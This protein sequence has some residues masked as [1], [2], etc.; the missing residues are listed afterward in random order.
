MSGE[1]K[2]PSQADPHNCT[3]G[4]PCVPKDLEFERRLSEFRKEKWSAAE[5]KLDIAWNDAI[6][7]AMVSVGRHRPYCFENHNL[8]TGPNKNCWLC[9]KHDE[10]R[11]LKRLDQAGFIP[12]KDRVYKKAEELLENGKSKSYRQGVNDILAFVERILADTE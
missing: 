9:W 2:A 4:H 1:I 3:C 10:L 7:A 6:E 8:P 11:K 5:M 12:L